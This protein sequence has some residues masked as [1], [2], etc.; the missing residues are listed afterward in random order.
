MQ[1]SNANFHECS[2]PTQTYN[3]CSGLDLPVAMEPQV[4]LVLNRLYGAGAWP[5]LVIV[6]REKILGTARLGCSPSS[7]PVLT[8]HEDDVATIDLVEGQ[9][10]LH[11]AGQCLIR[12]EPSS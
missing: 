5:H 3:L 12:S 11:P 8:C 4:R 6:T 1:Q 10:S 9:V 7:G 2:S